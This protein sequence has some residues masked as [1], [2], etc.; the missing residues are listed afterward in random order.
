MSSADQMFNTSL[1]AATTSV[2]QSE[3]TNC[4]ELLELEPDNKCTLCSRSNEFVSIIAEF[5]GAVETF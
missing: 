5:Y 4:K 3:L 2:L 1:T